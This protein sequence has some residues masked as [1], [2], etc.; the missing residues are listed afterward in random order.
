MWTMKSSSTP[1]LNSRSASV[2]I[3]LTRKEREFLVQLI[4]LRVREGL[5]LR[6]N[7]NLKEQVKKLRAELKQ[8]NESALKKRLDHAVHQLAGSRNAWLSKEEWQVI[9]EMR[10]FCT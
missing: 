3:E 2:T 6:E 1:P 7:E 8:C 9:L 4:D 5:L 10:G